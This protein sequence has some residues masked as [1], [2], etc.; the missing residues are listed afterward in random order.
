MGVDAWEDMNEYNITSLAYYYKHHVS[1]HDGTNEYFGK[2]GERTDRMIQNHDALAKFWS[3]AEREGSTT[4]SGASSNDV[5]LLGMHG[6]DLADDARLLATL[7]QM[8]R[9]DY[10]A[11]NFLLEKIRHII[12][13][14]PGMYDNPLLT[15][16][17]IAIQSV[18]PFDGRSER[19]SII[20]GDG[21]YEFLEWL[22]LGDD[23]VAYIHSHEY[24]HHLQYDLG[25]GYYGSTTSAAASA[26]SA[27][28]ETRWW[29][30]MADALG[31]Y[32]NA[33]SAGGRMDDDA[34]LNVHR[35]AFS[36]GDCEDTIGSHHGL[37][38]Q[39]EC[40]SNYGADLALVSYYNDGYVMPPS[41]LRDLFDEKYERIVRLDGEQCTAVVD[42]SVL[43][44]EIYG[45]VRDSEIDYSSYFDGYDYGIELSHSFVD[46]MDKPPPILQDENGTI[47]K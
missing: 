33:H 16:N 42:E 4:A 37:P 29:E 14:L 34:L 8:H 13:S 20:V 12:E 35:A 46:E 22:G 30:M 2:D 21:I 38:R 5:V 17:A 18:D 28:V 26:D 9:M 7:Q 25:I 6:V 1:G 44:V 23:G 3:T 10:G 36:L 47:A 11:A 15:A 45:D 31:S 32:F 43:D 27:A 19:D 39:R 41:V 40:A 24:A